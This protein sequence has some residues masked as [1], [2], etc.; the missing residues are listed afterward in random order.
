MM[1]TF[2][3]NIFLANKDIASYP[4]E[5]NKRYEILFENNIC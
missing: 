2:L 3:G 4:F 1:T 5:E